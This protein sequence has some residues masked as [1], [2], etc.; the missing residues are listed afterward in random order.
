MPKRQ[1]R[2]THHQRL[3]GPSIRLIQPMGRTI[4]KFIINI[5]LFDGGY[6]AMQS[7]TVL[8]DTQRMVGFPAAKWASRKSIYGPVGRRFVATIKFL[9]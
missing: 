9:V 7:S 8:L 4:I 1:N 6:K 3:Q 5:H 2:H